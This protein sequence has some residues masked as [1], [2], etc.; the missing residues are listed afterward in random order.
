MNSPFINFWKIDSKADY[1]EIRQGRVQREFLNE[2][3]M[4]HGYHCK[5]MTT[6]NVFGWEFLLPQDV[7]VIWDG[8]IDSSPDHIKIL[9]GE[10]YNGKKMVVTHTGNG[11]LTF[12]SNICIETDPEHLSIITVP[13][14]YL[15]DGAI[16][17]DITLRTD[18]F[19]FAETFFAWRITKPN[20]EITFKKGMPFMFLKNYPINLL[21]STVTE[22]K[23]FDDDEKM[24][25]NSKIHSNLRKDFHEKNKDS[26]SHFYRD[27]IT[28]NFPKGNNYKIFPKLKDIK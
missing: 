6:S 5:P 19:H 13:P 26:W 14:N 24:V 28:P 2:T 12:L 1:P 7:T 10:Y 15:F 25:N 21:E 8:I 27:G 3:Y 20:I 4:S 9:K 22:I 11:M 23:N 16:P 18:F 17:M